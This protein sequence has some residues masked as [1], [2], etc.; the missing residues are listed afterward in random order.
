ML[1]PAVEIKPYTPSFKAAPTTNGTSKSNGD[2]PK[3]SG[4]YVPPHLRAKQAAA[5]TQKRPQKTVDDDAD[6]FNDD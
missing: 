3:S 2:A 4:G 6:W 5:E 1:Q